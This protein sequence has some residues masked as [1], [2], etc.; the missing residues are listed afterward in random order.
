M[1]TITTLNTLR[2]R[3]P[4]AD[5][6]DRLCEYA[7]SVRSR[8]VAVQEMQQIEHDVVTATL[9]RI[10]QLYPNFLRY[11]AVGWDK[12]YR[13]MQLLL[14][15]MTKAMYLNDPHYYDH[16]VLTWVRTIFKSLN[17][18]PK[19]LRD[20]YSILRENVRTRAKPRTYAL[21]ESYLDHT[22]EYLAD[23]PEPVRPEV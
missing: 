3:Y 7:S 17:F 16:Q 1:L 10:K 18:T 23:I 19:F 22:I 21:M 12:G 6:R 9:D 8:L 13:D 2:D 11:H 20:S 15:Y 5:E 14:Q 4:T